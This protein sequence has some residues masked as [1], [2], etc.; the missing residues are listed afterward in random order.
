MESTN[1]KTVAIVPAAIA[2]SL[3][4][5]AACCGQK[6]TQPNNTTRCNQAKVTIDPGKKKFDINRLFFGVCPMFWKENDKDMADGLIEKYLKELPCTSLRFPGGTDSDVYLWDEH[7]LHDN[8]RWP[9]KEGPGTMDTDE[10]IALCRRIGAEPII[11]VNTEIAFF[12]SA[13]RAVRLAAEWVRYCNITKGYNVKYWEIGNEPYYHARFDAEEYARLFI[14]IARAMKAVDP[15]I[16]IAA[17][18][19]WNI[20]YEG[21]KARIPDEALEAAQELEYRAEQGKGGY[22]EKFRALETSTGPPW[23]PQVLEI[24]GNDIDIVSIHWY[25]R[26]EDLP[27]MTE[28]IE[29]LR[30]LCRKKVPDKDLPIIMTEWNVHHHV[31]VF[32]MRRALAV[33]EGIGRMLDAQVMM[34]NY[35]PL[36]CGGSHARKNLLHLTEK[37]PTAN[38]QVIH[39]FAKHVG[40][41]RIHSESS[42]ESVYHFASITEDGRASVFLINRNPYKINVDLILRGAAETTAQLRLLKASD[43][44][45]NSEDLSLEKMSVLMTRSPLQVE[46]PG[47]SILRLTAETGVA[48]GCVGATAGCTEQEKHELVTALCSSFENAGL[49]HKPRALGLQHNARI[50]CENIRRSPG[51]R[52]PRLPCRR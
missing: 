34:A 8:T 43:G 1:S 11:C 40:S 15:A 36:R 13:E 50:S 41:R 45:P 23:W 9:Y 31:E 16:Q 42:N 18:G 12:E 27:Q 28:T 30:S 4:F 17:V 33:G 25:Y 6:T 46:L 3:F 26:P 29:R 49:K 48:S 32:G 24:A 19:E 38:Y 39:L 10:F 14:R 52:E 47:F 2:V 20:D 22:Y 21:L 35:W 5:S 44:D 51:R 37:T 7:R